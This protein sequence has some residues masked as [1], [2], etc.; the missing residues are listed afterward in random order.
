[1]SE[2][3]HRAGT[4]RI[5]AEGLACTKAICNYIHTLTAAFPAAPMPR[6][7]GRATPVEALLGRPSHAS[8]QGGYGL[9]AIPPNLFQLFVKQSLAVASYA[10]D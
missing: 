2:A 9:T 5:C 4:I 8:A 3:E 10:L 1:M 7:R 6:R